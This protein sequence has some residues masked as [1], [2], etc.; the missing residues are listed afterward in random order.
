MDSRL[1]NIEKKIDHIIDLI[2]KLT[3]SCLQ[4]SKHIDFV[5]HVIQQYLKTPWFR[6][7]N[8]YKQVFALNK[9]PTNAT[10]ETNG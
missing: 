9:P 7:N 8:L 3:P 4:M 2:E 5:E 6:I 1:E 10:L